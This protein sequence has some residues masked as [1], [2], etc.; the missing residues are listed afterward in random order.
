MP[1]PFPGMDP[2]LEDPASWPN[3]HHG[4]ISELQ[5]R[6][7]GQLRPKYYARVEERVYISDQDDPGR[8]VIIPDV[9]VLTRAEREHEPLQTEGGGVAVAETV[10]AAEPVIMTT[11]I[12][13]EIHEP[14]VEVIDRATRRVVTVI[15]VVSPTNKLRGARGQESYRRKRTEVM[16]SPTHWVEI[17][18]LRE[19]EPLVSAE[20]L[21]RG[22]YF[23]HVSRVEERPS[24]RV[25]PILLPQRLP[26]IPIPLL[27]EDPDAPL[28][29]GQILATVYD[30]SA[31][32]L[33]IDYSAAAV[34]ALPAHY[35]EW[36]DRLLREKRVRG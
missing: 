17:D 23:V 30:R 13:D 7:T 14:R 33:D 34:P 32:D 3:F 18:L 19:G 2:Y 29:L 12:E 27:A 22:D 26:I 10:A 8:R 16:T 4:F 6:L 36:T 21:P 1:S 35:G 24:G 28:D 15:E 31:Y 25:W 20:M 11:L 9:R 5:G